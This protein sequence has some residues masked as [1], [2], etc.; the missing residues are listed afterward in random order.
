MFFFKLPEMT[1]AHELLDFLGSL[2]L[3]SL[4]ISSPG[5]KKIG[6]HSHCRAEREKV[7]LILMSWELTLGLIYFGLLCMSGNS[8]ECKWQL[9]ETS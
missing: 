3:P 9:L 5:K 4:R 1:F 8:S 2:V 7:T 6:K